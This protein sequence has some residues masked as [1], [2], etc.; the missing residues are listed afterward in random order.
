V[1]ILQQGIECDVSQRF[2]L[3]EN[4]VETNGKLDAFET[5]VLLNSGTALCHIMV[6]EKDAD[7]A[8]RGLCMLLKNELH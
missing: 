6:D 3:G 1:L 8:S 5:K 2:F 4:G 7:S